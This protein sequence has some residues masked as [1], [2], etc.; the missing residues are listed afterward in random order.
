MSL[1]HNGRSC[2]ER[3]ELQTSFSSAVL[4]EQP[5][6]NQQEVQACRW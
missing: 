3:Q 2:P 5:Y 1:S 6:V 4:H